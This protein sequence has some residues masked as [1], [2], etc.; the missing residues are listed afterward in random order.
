MFDLTITS[1]FFA[2]GDVDISSRFDFS[3]IEAVTPQYLTQF[4]ALTDP[5]D[6]WYSIFDAGPSTIAATEVVFGDTSGNALEILGTNF[7]TIT[8][9]ADINQAIQDLFGTSNFS[10][11]NIYYGGTVIGNFALATDGYTFSSGSES[12]FFGGTLPT[13]FADIVTLVTAVQDLLSGPVSDARLLE[14]VSVFDL[15]ATNEVTLSTSEE[16]A[17]ETVVTELFSYTETSTVLTLEIAG[18]S[19]VALGTFPA[20]SFSRLLSAYNDIMA[21]LMA[22]GTV[23]FDDVTGLDVT[24][25]NFTDANGDTILSLMGDF[26]DAEIGADGSFGYGT[27]PNVTVEGS[28]GNDDVADPYFTDEYA[29]DVVVE[30]NAG[31]DNFEIDGSF[32]AYAYSF[33][34]PI[35]VDGGD[36]YDSIEVEEWNDTSVSTTIDV[37]WTTQ[38]IQAYNGDFGSLVESYLVNFTNFER[39]DIDLIGSGATVLGDGGNNRV[40]LIQVNGYFEFDGGAGWDRL[41]LHRTENLDGSRGLTLDELRAAFD[42][43]IKDN[44]EIAIMEAGDPQEIGVLENVEEI[45]L[46]VEEAGVARSDWQTEEYSVSEVLGLADFTGTPFDGTAGDD[47]IKGNSLDNTINGFAGDDTIRDYEGD[48]TIDAG[49]G[50]DF[51][52]VAGG[53]HDLDGGDD[54]DWDTLWLE[55]TTAEVVIVDFLTSGTITGQSSETSPATVYFTSAV[56]NFD[57]FASGV[58]GF[59]IFHAG[60]DGNGSYLGIDVLPSG[61]KYYGTSDGFDTLSFRW[62]FLGDNVDDGFTR[63]EFEAAFS[64]NADPSDPTHFIITYLTGADAGTVFGEVWDVE[65]IQ[66]WNDARDDQVSIPVSELA[67]VTDFIGTDGDDRIEAN[68]LDN[69]I[70]GLDGDDSIFGNGDEGGGDTVDAGAGHDY[71][72]LEVGDHSVDGGADNDSVDILDFSS[73]VFVVDLVSGTIS[74]YDTLGGV[75]NYTTTIAN[76][77]N[78]HTNTNGAAYF[79]GT[80]APFYFGID[81]VPSELYVYNGDGRGTLG[82]RWTDNGDGTHGLTLAELESAFELAAIDGTG[83]NFDIYEL[84]PAG[85]R[86]NKIGELRGVTQIQYYDASAVDGRGRANLADIAVYPDPIVGTTGPDTL[87]GT[88]GFDVILGFAGDDDISGLGGPDLI[89]SGPGSDTLDGGEGDDVYVV[90]PAGL[91]DDIGAELNSDDLIDTDAVVTILDSGGTDTMRLLGFPDAWP[92]TFVWDGSTITATSE[93]GHQIVFGSDAG[94]PIIEQ[95]EYLALDDNFAERYTTTFNLVVDQDDFTELG[96]WYAGT[97]SA[98]VIEAPNL[99]SDTARSFFGVIYG[100]GGDDTITVYH[101]FSQGIYGGEGNDAITV[102]G[103]D[104]GAAPADASNEDPARNWIYGEDGNDTI[105]MAGGDDFASGGAGND[106]INAGA[107]NDTIEGDEGDDNLAGGDGDDFVDGGAGNDTITLGSGNDTIEGGLGVDT[108]VI[109]L[110]GVAADAYV[111]EVDL[112]GDIENVGGVGISTL[113]DDVTGIEN[114][115]LIGDVS[116][117]II[118]SAENNYLISGEGNDTILA[119]EGENTVESNG[120]DDVI[121]V[122]RNNATVDGGAGDD[123]LAI[124]DIDSAVLLIDLTTGTATGQSDLTDSAT[125]DYTTAFSNIETLAWN[126]QNTVKVIGNGGSDVFSPM[127][128]PQMLI[129]DN[130]SGT[131]ILDF[132]KVVNDDDSIG[133]NANDL[134]PYIIRPI[135]ATGKNFKVF[136]E[137]GGAEVQVAELSGVSQIRFL[138]ALDETEVLTHDISLYAEEFQLLVEGL[139][140]EDETLSVDGSLTGFA[141]PITYQWTRDGVNINGATGDQYTLG[142]DDVGFSISVIVTG[143]GTDEV[144][145]AIG[146]SEVSNVND[147][148]TGVPVISGT[149]QQGETLSVDISGIDD[150]DGVPSEIGYQWKRGGTEI[151][152]ATNATYLLTE[153]DIGSVISVTVSFTDDQGTDESVDSDTTDTVAIDPDAEICDVDLGEHYELYLDNQTVT[154]ADTDGNPTFLS[155]FVSAFV[156]HPGGYV[157][158]PT[159]YTLI[160]DADPLDQ[161]GTQE[162]VIRAFGNAVS[163]ANYGFILQDFEEDGAGDEDYASGNFAGAGHSYTVSAYGG[164]T[165][166][167][168]S[169]SMSDGTA[170]GT[171]VV[172][173]VM[174]VSLFDTGNAAAANPDNGDDPGIATNLGNDADRGYNKTPV[175]N[176][177]LGQYLEA[178]PGEEDNG[179][180]LLCFDQGTT[181]YGF[182][183]NL[184]GRQDDK[185][186]VYLDIHF[187][188]GT[189][190]RTLTDSDGQQEGGE[191][192]FSFLVDP[193]ESDVSI[194]AVVFYEP[195]DATQDNAGDRDIFSI[196]DLAL[197]VGQNDADLTSDEYIS[198]IGLNTETGGALSFTGDLE[199]DSTLTAD[200]T[201]LTDNDGLPGDITG[202]SF[203]WFRGDTAI[204]GATGTEYTLTQADVGSTITLQASFID[205]QGHAEEISS[206][207]SDPVA[208]LNDAPTGGVT[209]S[210]TAEQGQTLTAENTLGDEDGLGTLNYQWIRDGVDIPDAIDDQYEL[211]QADVGKAITVRVSYT[212]GQGTN[213]SSTSD[214][215]DPVTNIN[216]APTGVLLILGTPEE[217]ATLTAFTSALKDDD[218]LG[219]LSFQWIR[220]GVDIPDATDAD[221][222]LTSADIGLPISLRVSFEDGFGNVE[223]FTSDAT[224]P[225]ENVNDPVEGNVTITGNATEGEMLTA[226]VSGLSDPDGMD[227]ATFAYQWLRD[228]APIRGATLGTYDLTG[229]DVGA[230]ISVEVSFTDDQGTDESST[231]AAT[232][233]VANVNDDPVGAVLISGTNS[234]GETLTA[235]AAGLSDTDGLGDFSFQWL[236]DGVEIAGATG[237][238]YNLVQADVDAEISVRVDYTDGQGTDESVTSDPTNPVTNVNTSPT[239][240]V[241]ITGDAQEGETLTADPSGL[242]DADGLGVFSY[243]WLRGGAPI[244]GAT[245]VSYV[246]TADD[247]DQAISVEV[248]YTDGQGTTEG[249]T[250][251]ETDPVEA[252]VIEGTDGADDLTGNSLDNQVNGNDGDDTMT[253]EVGNDT[254]DGGAGDDNMDGGEGDD[255][256]RVDGNTVSEDT[257]S[258][259]AGTDTLVIYNYPGLDSATF[260]WN[261]TTVTRTTTYGHSTIINALA[262]IPVIE[263]IR[264]VDIDDNGDEVGSRTLDLVVDQS[265]FT[266]QEVVFAGTDND[267]TIT[268]PD[269]AA[270]GSANWGEIFG[271]GGNDTITLSTLFNQFVYAGSGNDVVVEGTDATRDGSTINNLIQGQEGDDDITMGGGDDTIFGGDGDD[272]IRDGTGNDSVDGGKDDDQFFYTSGDSDEY[273]GGRGYDFIDIDLSGESDP[274]TFTIDLDAGEMGATGRM[275]DLLNSIEGVRVIGD[276]DVTVTGDSA[277]NTIDLDGGDDSVD[278]GGGDD[279][280]YAGEGD[281]TVNGED[282]DDFIEGDL[283]T[284]VIDGGDG[285]DTA[286]YAGAYDDYAIVVDGNGFDV[287][288]TGISDDVE[289]VEIFSFSDQ[290]FTSGMLRIGATNDGD[291]VG[292]SGST[293]GQDLS[294]GGGD[295]SVS[296]GSGNDTVDAGADNDTVQGGAGSDTINGGSG[297]DSVG[298]GTG[299]DEIFDGL[300]NDT[301]GGGQGSDT[302]IALSGNNSFVEEDETT[303]ATDTTLDDYYAGGYG[304][305]EFFGGGG[306]DVL[307]GDRGSAFYFGDDTMTGGTGDDILQGSGGADVFIFRSGD[308]DDT[309]GTVD[310]RTVGSATDITDILITGADFEVGLDRVDLT[311]FGFASSADVLA[312]LSDVGG[313]ATLTT[314]DGTI[315]FYD[316]LSADLGADDFII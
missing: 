138:N 116:V 202:Y 136:I 305:D 66:F 14:I 6:A 192:Y 233:A 81:S 44:G 172:T 184:I 289:N 191:Q 207:A 206:A 259:S 218:G 105:V 230:A 225:V 210:G 128:A 51:V 261:G 101:Q 204:G 265:D 309:I 241:V 222:V 166:T 110:T 208:N 145:T 159:G 64:V 246:V 315:T 228:G 231:S 16:V 88:D 264:W 108:L 157:S 242:A 232:D 71:V 262:G 148:A 158:S 183:V 188:D 73:A 96:T 304:D 59:L 1:D 279:A 114:V 113:R 75:A 291:D 299:D 82:F 68:G 286:L 200:I 173:D 283:G 89:N 19:I 240:S 167:D 57:G 311:D 316:I 153:D 263:K 12:I 13:S 245:A 248:T 177:E 109:D 91:V 254:L 18:A 52:A 97:D 35:T 253:G 238:A 7:G 211:V 22:D 203:Q 8:S 39:V 111:A 146:T 287:T 268:A 137:D 24:S 41:E 270:D 28:A 53:A 161:S 193:N 33:M 144:E 216:D 133:L 93:Y 26:G 186:P 142:Q 160:A 90:F 37:D 282:G 98:D 178:L 106:S 84:D 63:A 85:A 257:I 3:A 67:G 196:D 310:L 86:G 47:D 92:G 115:T 189:V 42:F 219:D 78:A 100:N 313:N 147:A 131:G 302:G 297:D 112:T 107:G 129:I 294:S 220:D 235:N 223:T 195:Y 5:T 80:G 293:D 102:I 306:N 190:Y 32:R 140:V 194:V 11:F 34:A 165:H 267:D 243:Q 227:G 162:F 45:R 224:D 212:D 74:G 65:D 154:D 164:T 179:G 79:Y 273:D 132:T 290:V 40:R 284:N 124:I 174:S 281:D 17:G 2:S 185:R 217:G 213:E 197:V 139:A 87:G 152:G 260:V 277:S 94:A 176:P 285:T 170:D 307:V 296:G 181:V 247:A 187:S 239:G 127:F 141:E 76:V 258:D 149:A 175:T 314:T 50:S 4:T 25:F 308:G 226:D 118:G 62:T 10:E 23:S 255:E 122:G 134:L 55:D 15:Y 121:G 125:I 30:L 256:Y 266:S 130:G 236:R 36:G 221:Y 278:A 295:D 303:E 54:E 83:R 72:R 234:E 198:A 46:L 180:I 38:T 182:G 9:L 271:N 237:Q 123:L 272:T 275:T 201:G 21:A 300:G 171:L 269:V 298:G 276:V 214:P 251:G 119:D 229:D 31:D 215:T 70:Q 209:I 150:E 199:E 155:Q 143:S 151:A 27:L 61:F 120:G 280:V 56:Q 117:D 104:A 249:V 288:G 312:L 69:D 49:A 29:Q 60:D 169:G 244:P 77:E 20:G 43:A 205:G 292:D 274:F 168:A 126:N 48:N 99:D 163:N 95:I 135:D 156:A 250:S 301:I 252:F 58:E 103:G